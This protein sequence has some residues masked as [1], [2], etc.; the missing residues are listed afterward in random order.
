[1]T[2]IRKDKAGIPSTRLGSTIFFVLDTDVYCRLYVH[3]V[4][5]MACMYIDLSQLN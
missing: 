4:V 5:G 1:M 3:A 2:S